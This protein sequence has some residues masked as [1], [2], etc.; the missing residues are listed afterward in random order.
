MNKL[1]FYKR[2]DH[3]ISIIRPQALLDW[4][5]FRPYYS[6]HQSTQQ[7]FSVVTDWWVLKRTK[8]ISVYRSLW[9]DN[10]I[11]I[12]N[13]F[14]KL[15]LVCCHSGLSCCYWYRT[16]FCKP[17]LY[18]WHKFYKHLILFLNFHKIWKTSSIILHAGSR[19]RAMHCFYYTP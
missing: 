3:T 19:L 13:P 1:K 8:P 12:I 2:V 10:R 18:F 6:T 11:G 9:N 15:K 7:V 5:R 17:L 4:V 16:F 14:V